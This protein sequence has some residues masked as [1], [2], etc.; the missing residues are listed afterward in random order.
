MA[1]IHVRPAEGR[2]VR[3]P[4]DSAVIPPEGIEIER[5]LFV[6]RRLAAGDLVVVVTT[7]TPA[8]A[9]DPRPGRKETR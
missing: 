6:V 3:N 8:A 1:R 5:D 2:R 9:A 4:A 7:G